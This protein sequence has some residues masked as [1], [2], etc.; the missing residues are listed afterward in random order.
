MTEPH[1]ALPHDLAQAA[2]S[3]LRPTFGTLTPGRTV[4]L[5]GS[6]RSLTVRTELHP[7]DGGPDLPVVLKSPRRA[8]PGT[9]REEA[10]LAVLA[11]TSAPVPALLAVVD[12]PVPVLVMADLGS[13]PSLADRL[14]GA[15]PHA[16]ATA[17]LTWADALA[18]VHVAAAGQWD[19]FSAALD[20]RS[21]LGPPP[22]DPTDGNLAQAAADLERQLSGLGVTGPRVTAALAELREIAAALWIDAQNAHR[23]VLGPGDTCPDNNVE[24][25]DG[26]MLL[27]FEAAA[28]THPAWEAAYLTVP[29][30][31][32]WC[33]WRLPDDVAAAAL[34]R[35]RNRVSAVLPWVAGAGFADDLRL[36]TTAWAWISTSYFLPAALEG[37]PPTTDPTRPRPDRVTTIQHRL[38]A[39]VEETPGNTTN[40]TPALTAL[41]ERVLDAAVREWGHRTLPLAPAWR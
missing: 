3:A 2:A 32:C 30:P 41:A 35:W 1:A 6:D 5:S 20:R 10:A 17:V 11:G 14:R 36:A 9:V 28:I 12:E 4:V 15:D 37:D 29:W 23:G 26:L 21:P 27:D 39:Q 8:G 38:R 24:T 7:D 18:A 34:G 33:A 22:A 31:T 25:P 40:A 16:A 13:G 19:V